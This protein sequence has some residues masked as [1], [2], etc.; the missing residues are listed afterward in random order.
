MHEG[1]AHPTGDLSLDV[2]RGAAAVP[3]ALGQ[4]SWSEWPDTLKLSNIVATGMPQRGLDDEVNTWRLRN[5]R[6]LWRGLRRILAAKALG[7]PTIYGALFLDVI[8]ADGHHVP[9]GLA[10]LRVVTTTGAGY[11]V[12]AWQNIT[13]LENMKYHGI[14]TT[15]TAENVADSALAAESTTALNPDST[16]ATGTT[17]EASATVFR[18]V[19]TLTADASI[20]AVEHGLLSQAATGGGVLFDRSTFTVVNL[21]SGDSLQATYDA[22]IAAGS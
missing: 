9:L 13:E 12:D 18:S 6:N 7:V 10:S 5:Q 14:G 22:T 2:I 3:D 11:I 20:A 15:A 21:A 19:G 4:I 8:R 16:R 1:T 17:A